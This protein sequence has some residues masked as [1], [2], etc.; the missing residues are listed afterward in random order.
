M[1]RG[2]PPPVVSAT[3]LGRAGDPAPSS[4]VAALQTPPTSEGVS[5]FHIVWGFNAALEQRTRPRELLWRT[6]TIMSCGAAQKE[7]WAGQPVPERRTHV[8]GAREYPSRY[9]R[10]LPN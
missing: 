1:Y 2:I 9:R 4:H 6:V 10:E 8:P 3:G 5:S 7:G